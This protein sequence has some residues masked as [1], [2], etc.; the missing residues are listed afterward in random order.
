M[1]FRALS[2][3]PEAGR[4][5]T[6]IHFFFEF[7]LLG[8]LASGYL[9]VL[10]SGYLDLPTALMTGLS[11]LARVGIV[12]GW[13][14]VSP[15]SRTIHTLTLAYV[16]FYALDYYWISRDFLT[17]TVHLVFFLATVK[18]LT[19]QTERD[20]FFVKIIAFIELLA[21]SILSTDANFFICLALFFL[22]GV[23][24]FAAS[25]IRRAASQS[26][27]VV[28]LAGK[29]FAS[30]LA[31][32]TLFTVLGI[33]LLSGGL[34]FLLPRTARAALQRFVPKNSH[35]PGFSQEVTLGQIG[36][37]QMQ[38]TAVMHVRILQ[39]TALPGL[40][41]R[42]SALSHFDGKKWFNPDAA[43]EV[44]PVD[45]A[46]LLRLTSLEQQLT[47]ARRI[48]YQVVVQDPPSDVL[49]FAGTPEALQLAASVV[50]RTSSGTY[51]L[52]YGPP[53][54][55]RYSAYS[56]IEWHSIPAQLSQPLSPAE[57]RANLQLPALDPRVRELALRLVAGLQDD[58]ARAS[59]IERHLAKSYAYTTELPKRE[60]AEPVADFLFSRKKGHCEYFASSMVVLLRSLGI[61]ARLVTGFQGGIF[62]P[63]SGWYLIRASDAH[64]WVEAWLPGKG[65]TTFDPTPPAAPQPLSLATRLQ[66]Y[67]DAVQVF[68]QDWILAYDLDRQLNLVSAIEQS[69]PRFSWQAWERRWAQLE[70]HLVLFGRRLRRLLPEAIQAL[71]VGAV[72]FTL[73]RALWRKWRRM[74]E[75]RRLERGQAAASDAILLY[76]RMLATLQRRGVEK[77]PWLTPNEF[78]KLLPRPEISQLVSEATAAYHELRYGQRQEAALRFAHLVDELEHTCRSRNPL[79]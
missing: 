19:A 26:D 63:L 65:W 50:L 35:V 44:L 49:F 55:L 4:R 29:P 37:F 64:S 34:F 78:A 46:G 1:T 68:W 2:F 38:N 16:L 24:T 48:S 6:P 66:L 39:N 58:A 71:V 69:R 33:L 21:A 3:G 42:G 11:L 31:G 72:L 9:A 62:N 14:R 51:R 43:E 60:P 18:I 22:F 20:Y 45:S 47:P 54:R 53:D 23:A 28:H 56:V 40:K 7:S 75:R 27:A 30:R 13:I 5:P 8:L 73:T 25:E 70:G 15:S 57:R 32:L 77:P 74:S 67:L 36:E 10:G 76:Q 12:L 41:W 79:R 52:G 61:P 17:A 59:A